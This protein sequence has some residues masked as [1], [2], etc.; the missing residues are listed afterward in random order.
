MT[1]EQIKIRYEKNFIDT[2]YM[3]KRKA[4]SMD[5]S[6][7]ELMIYYT[8]K[9]YKVN[10]KSFA[11]NLN[12]KTTDGSFNLLA[13]L[14]SDKNSIPLIF[15]KFQGNNK[16]SISERSDYGYGC[17][18]SSYEKLKNRLV[19]ENINVS[20]TRV[21]PRKDIYLFDFDSVN[22]AVINALVHNDWTITEPQVSMF[23]DR[24]EILSHGGLPSGM[25][26]SQFFEG[27]SKPRN[28]TLM[29][30]FLTMGLAEH[31]GH[32]IPTIID[33]YGKD[34]FQI[35]D[36][37]IRCTIP[38]DKEVLSQIEKRNVGLN[39]GLNVGLNKTETKV[40]HLLMENPAYN[41]EGLAKKVGVTKRTI[42]R[43]FASLQKKGFLER[44]GSKRDGSWMV[45]K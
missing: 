39:I 29:R 42:E 44:V 20:N 34:V 15:V 5:L 37:Y 41:A 2:E 24:L 12:L 36:N 26:E 23:H 8:E 14:L 35:E 25:S 28:T 3:L 40:I 13:E 7:K 11:A 38:F 45:I 43:T 16:T 18:I 31:T 4:S 19:A 30:I 1:P 33:R 6:F 9:G 32:G 22:E 27:I 17:L 21:R 10:D